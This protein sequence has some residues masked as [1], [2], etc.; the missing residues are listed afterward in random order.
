MET[1]NIHYA[2]THLSKLIEA[3]LNGEEVVIA[4][5]G[6][7]K[8]KLVAVPLKKKKRIGGQLKGKIWL[9]D[10]WD[11]PETNKE[12]EDLFYNSGISDEGAD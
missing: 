5:S 8:V 9:A 7:P 3:V 2:K 4:K 12:I 10:D 1:V 6:V 11:S